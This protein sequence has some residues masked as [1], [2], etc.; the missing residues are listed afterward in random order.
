MIIHHLHL[1]QAIL[2][3]HE[4]HAP[5]VIDPDAVLSLSVPM[6]G[7]QAIAGESGQVAQTGS[8]VQDLQASFSLRLHSLEAAHPLAIEQGFSILVTKGAFGDSDV[9]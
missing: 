2:P 8:T 3:P 4:A 9:P 5:L 7:F 6:Q 1:V